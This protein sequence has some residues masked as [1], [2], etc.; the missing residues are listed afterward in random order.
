M[1]I[2][3]KK[4]KPDDSSVE[5]NKCE[6]PSLTQI[7]KKKDAAQEKFLALH[8]AEERNISGQFFTPGILALDIVKSLKPF[9]PM[10][11]EFLDPAF[12]F[13]SLFIPLLTEGYQIERAVAYENDA[14]VA[15]K[16]SKIW[17]QFIDL[18]CCDFLQE[19]PSSL[20]NLIIS[21][22]PYV[23]H[24]HLPPLIKKSLYQKVL[25]RTGIKVSG[26]S[27]LYVYF[28]LLSHIWMQPRAIAVWILPTE[29]MSVNY[30]V[31]LQTYLTA[32]VSLLRIHKFPEE[33]AKFESVLTTCAIVFLCNEKCSN[34]DVEFTFG[35]L[36]APVSCNYVKVSALQQETK[37]NQFFETK[38]SET[39]SSIVLGRNAFAVFEF[40]R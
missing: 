11:I 10:S 4:R 32:H 14:Y 18:H 6:K 35:D 31:S 22:P 1:L 16:A 28:V 24:H 25:D 5:N 23:R 2:V 7:Q 12:G 15:K 30:G 21:N 8:N 38:P 9:M 20:F 39:V 40:F 19:T 37:W 3:E 36:A 34:K 27:S 17:N 29:F 26:L 13:G 33:T